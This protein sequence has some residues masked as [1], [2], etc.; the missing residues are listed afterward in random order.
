MEEILAP[1]PDDTIVPL[2]RFFAKNDN[3][4]VAASNAGSVR[5]SSA[6]FIDVDSWP[7]ERRRG[8]SHEWNDEDRDEQQ[9]VTR[10]RIAGRIRARTP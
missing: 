9:E 8:Q 2:L 7:R 10:K 1:S 3:P 4:S 6:V 5:I